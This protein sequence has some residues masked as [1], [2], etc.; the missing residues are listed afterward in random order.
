MAV[1]DWRTAP[2]RC[3]YCALQLKTLCQG[4]GDN[5]HG[6]GNAQKEQQQ[7][8]QQQEQQQQQQHPLEGEQ[9]GGLHESSE[10][11]ATSPQSPG[12]SS[13]H[14]SSK[15]SPPVRGYP[16]LVEL[17]L[18]GSCVAPGLIINVEALQGSCP[19][20]EVLSLDG[21]GALY[22]EH[23]WCKAR[24]QATG[25]CEVGKWDRAVRGRVE[26]ACWRR[27]RGAART[28]RCHHWM[29]GGVLR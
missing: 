7:Q 28:S 15:K 14:P 18:T 27:R 24:V 3:I 16:H 12:S 29:V 22:G 10:A 4:P 20:L 6:N 1:V 9:P 19:N 8:E 2:Y 25:Q 17:D 5:T 21:V 26:V 23:E 13:C 11:P